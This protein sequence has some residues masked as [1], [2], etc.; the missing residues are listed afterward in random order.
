MLGGRAED[1]YYV[2]GP[3]GCTSAAALGQMNTSV[4][5]GSLVATHGTDVRITLVLIVVDAHVLVL[6]IRQLF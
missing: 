3:N 6:K 2:D 5:G 4:T 1:R